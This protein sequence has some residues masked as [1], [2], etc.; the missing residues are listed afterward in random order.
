MAWQLAN[1]PRPLSNVEEYLSWIKGAVKLIRSLDCNHMIHLGSEGPTPW[2]SYVGTDI[3]RDHELMDYVGVHVWPQNWGWYD[4]MSKS[5]DALQVASEKA[6]C[7]RLPRLVSCQIRQNLSTHLAARSLG[8]NP[9]LPLAD[10][11]HAVPSSSFF[12]LPHL[13]SVSRVYFT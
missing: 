10:H 13:I 12:I 5:S 6:V 8:L 3:V 11:A 7:V 4:P 9:P 2:P 1:E